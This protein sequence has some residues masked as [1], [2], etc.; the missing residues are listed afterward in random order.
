MISSAVLGRYAK[1][2]AEVVFEENIESEA[3]G[4]LETY[5]E[6]F[7][8][9]PDL[10]DAFHSPAIP[11]EAKGKLLTE[12]MSRYPV[13]PITS[14]FLRVLLKHNRMVCF[15]QIFQSYRKAVNERKGIVSAIVST[16]SPL[17]PPEA[18]SL[19]GKLAALTGKLVNIEMRTDAGL[20]GGAVVQIG[21]TVFDGSIR[22][23]LDAV[24]R[25]LSEP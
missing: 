21:S 7:R 5:Q 15:S 6:I 23:Q 3:T 22:A 4:D 10:L 1:S 20:L 17:S 8:A 11:R 14:N 19:A 25:R 2:L 16:A 9:V 24:K 13:H 12:L 18:E